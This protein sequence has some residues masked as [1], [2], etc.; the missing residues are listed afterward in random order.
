MPD[1]QEYSPQHE[2]RQADEI[3][4]SKYQVAFGVVS[5]TYGI[6]QARVAD[7]LYDAVYNPTEVVARHG[8]APSDEF[9]DR[10]PTL[11]AALPDNGGAKPDRATFVNAIR[12]AVTR[13]ID[14]SACLYPGALGLVEAMA[15]RGP[16]AIWSQGDMYG[17][18]TEAP[19]SYEQIK[20]VVG[21]GIGQI[22]RKIFLGRSAVQDGR[23][24]RQL[25][26]VLTVVLDEDKFSDAAISRLTGYFE[27]NGVNHVTILEDRLG[28]LQRL[29]A[30]LED[31]GLATQGI[32]VRQGRY[33]KQDL[34][35]DESKIQAVASLDEAVQALGQGAP[36]GGYITDF[37]GVLS[38]QKQR[39]Q[40]QIA[41]VQDT[42]RR[43]GWL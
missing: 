35:F 27:G 3:V 39:L 20:K 19:G 1:I 18:G 42:I 6:N 26:D 23:E 2:T 37:D 25:N 16:T 13:E 34:P 36:D 38:N 43:N 33:G 14:H 41:A 30:A 17:Q 40:L 31:K 10:L 29:Q 15:E 22:R 24:G 9:P 32:W 12:G 11:E 28:N 4:G 21:A 7:V 5:D 8:I